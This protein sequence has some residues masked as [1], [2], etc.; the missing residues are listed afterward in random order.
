MTIISL[1]VGIFLTVTFVAILPKMVTKFPCQVV[2]N[3]SSMILPLGKPVK[4]PGT[5]HP[6]VRKSVRL[7]LL[8]YLSGTL[9]RGN[10]SFQALVMFLSTPVVFLSFV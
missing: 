9:A 2:K 5:S 7:L 8:L 1:I 6:C 10:P 4:R 3:C